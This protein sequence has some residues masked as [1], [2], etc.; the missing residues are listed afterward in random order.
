MINEPYERSYTVI[1]VVLNPVIQFMVVSV[2]ASGGLV[3][4]WSWVIFRRAPYKMLMYVM[5]VF[6]AFHYVALL[7]RMT[8]TAI[9]FLQVYLFLF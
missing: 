9:Y 1:A 2:I 3:Q 5:S 6:S 8:V 7:V 4:K